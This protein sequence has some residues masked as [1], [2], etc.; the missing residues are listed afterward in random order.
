MIS[1]ESYFSEMLTAPSRQFKGKVELYDG[2]TLLETFYHDGAL[3]SLT[4]DRAGESSKFFGFSICQQLTLKLRDKERTINIAK[5]NGLKVFMGVGEGY[6]CP[7]PIFFVDDVKRDENNNN[8]TIVAHDAINKA[9][10]H[11]VVELELTESYTIREFTEVVASFLGTP[12]KASDLTAFDTLYENGAN[13]NGVM[14]LRDALNAVAEA[15]QTICYIDY[16]GELTFRRLDKDGEP[17]LYIPKSQYFTLTS[18][19]SHTLTTIMSVTELGNNVH[20]T[21][22]EEGD[23]QYIRENPFL[24]LRDDVGDLLQDAIDAVGGMTMTQ[25]DCKHRGNFLLQLGDKVGFTTKDDQIIH[26]YIIDDSFTYSGGFVETTK[27]N[28][29]NIDAETHSNP[30]TL[31]DALKYTSARVDKANNRIE[32]V[33][34][35]VSS[36]NDSIAALQLDTES[37]S[38]SVSRVE[39]ATNESLEDINGEIG[40]LTSQIET[41]MTADEV[42]IQI[43]SAL[44][45]GVASVKTS[46]GYTFDENGMTVSKSGSQMT[47]TISEDGMIVYRDNTKVLI[48]DNEGVQAEDLHATTYL[49]I[50]T[51]SRFEDYG[52]NRTGCFWINS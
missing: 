7:C 31:G 32:L 2:S 36:Q 25:F 5:G 23:T 52:D 49:I 9:A 8:L 18:K 48:A 10:E 39:Q 43:S 24:D 33:A 20:A 46:T 13:F 47:T 1:A 40:T 3:Q 41:K 26:G 17:V 12:M 37:I 27:L 50:G 44:A 35:D 11:T 42:Q 14:T 19:T 30:S 6:I 15:T 22:G 34:S 38:A 4:V 21:T 16:T 51:H 29:E 45:N 28:F